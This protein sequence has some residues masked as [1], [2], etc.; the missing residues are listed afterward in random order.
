MFFLLIFWCLGASA[1]TLTV[2]F[3][4]V[5]QGDAILLQS[6][7]GRTALVD[8]G[9]RSSPVVDQLRHLEV[10]GLNLV[11]A[12]HAHADHIGGMLDVLESFPPNLYVDQGMAHT[13]A[14]YENLMTHIERS[15]QA[16]RTARAGQSFNLGEEVFI[17][18]CIKISCGLCV[19]MQGLLQQK[20]LTKG[21]NIC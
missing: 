12:T 3:L 2:S 11:I 10:E 21:S 8:A 7:D 20:N 5:G 18:I 13:S 9:P 15:G 6:P 17:E 19:N 4:E 14:T 1:G 16:Y